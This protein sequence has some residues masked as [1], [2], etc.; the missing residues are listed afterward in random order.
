M[1]AMTLM[2]SRTRTMRSSLCIDAGGAG[3]FYARR[4]GDGVSSVKKGVC[5]QPSGLNRTDRVP[6]S[7]LSITRLSAVLN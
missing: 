1:A 3:C 7:C 6:S 4:L 2:L 5:Y